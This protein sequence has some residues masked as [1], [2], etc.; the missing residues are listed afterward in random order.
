MAARELSVEA[1]VKAHFPT[2]YIPS[3]KDGTVEQ[4]TPGG[5]SDLMLSPAEYRAY[6]EAKAK[7]DVAGEYDAAVTSHR[8]VVERLNAAAYTPSGRSRE[9]DRAETAGALTSTLNQDRTSK[10]EAQLAADAKVMEEAYR[11][12]DDSEAAFR[13]FQNV[14]KKSAAALILDH[15][16]D[17]ERRHKRLQELAEHSRE[18]QRVKIREGQIAVERAELRRIRSEEEE[19]ERAIAME[20]AKAALKVTE[21][22]GRIKNERRKNAEAAAEIRC[23][24]QTRSKLHDLTHSIE[25]DFARSC[26]K[27]GIYRAL[28]T[29]LLAELE[30]VEAELA[31][32]SRTPTPPSE[33]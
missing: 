32:A 26:P 27:A 24:A 17:V 7:E 6:H 12:R 29:A 15:E 22:V 25:E 18:L 20:K 28:R 4:Y 33:S 13:H 19:R 23:E 1:R 21:E 11:R 8:E 31:S 5:S 16:H 14:S 10:R 9:I 2:H 3:D 30:L